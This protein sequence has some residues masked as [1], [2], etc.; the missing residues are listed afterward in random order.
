MQIDIRP[1]KRNATKFPSDIRNL[2]LSE[3]D[4]VDKN[5][6]FAKTD[7]WFRLLQLHQDGAEK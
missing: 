2:I 7:V 3:P 4:Y 6:F 1:M 5:D